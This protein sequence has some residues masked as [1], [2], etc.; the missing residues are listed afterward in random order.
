MLRLR[1]GLESFHQ[2]LLYGR[3]RRF[4]CVIVLVITFFLFVDPGNLQDADIN[5][6]QSLSRKF[7]A[8]DCGP[9]DEHIEQQPGEEEVVQINLSNVNSSKLPLSVKLHSDDPS[10]SKKS[11]GN[12]GEVDEAEEKESLEVIIRPINGKYVKSSQLAAISG[13]ALWRKREVVRQ[14]KSVHYTTIDEDGGYQEL[15][16]KETTQ[17][18]V[19]HMECR[20]TGEFAH[21]ELTEFEQVETFNDEVSFNKPS[22]RKRSFTLMAYCCC[23][24]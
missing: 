17:T 1:K 7:D 6:P 4:L 9:E 11:K 10:R 20:E 16:E 5:D 12:S 21:R 2:I 24:W 22:N 8:K 19:L 18:E 3:V 14:E 15:V 13:K 23:S